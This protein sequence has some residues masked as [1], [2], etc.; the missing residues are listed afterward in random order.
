[1]MNRGLTEPLTLA[2]ENHLILKKYTSCANA[3]NRRVICS[4]S[5]TSLSRLSGLREPLSI[6]AK[7]AGLSP[8]EGGIFGR[9]FPLFE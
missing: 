1:M 2:D 6:D 8:G 4:S 7:V 3:K 5:I 9:I